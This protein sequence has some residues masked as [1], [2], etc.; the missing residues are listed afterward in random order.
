MKLRVL[1]LGKRD[2]ESTLNI[3]LDL[4][5]KRQRGLIEDTLVLVEHPPVITM[6]LSAKDSNILM[7]EKFLMEQGIDVHR[8]ARGGDVTYHGDGQIVGYPI[9]NLKESKL[10]IRN[11]V[12]GMEK[13]FI[14]ILID[15]F[16]INAAKDP[17]HTGVWVG[18]DKIVAIG[19]AVKHGVTMHGFAFNVNT[20]LQHFD[21]I[22]PCGLNDRGVTSIEKIKG[23]KQDFENINELVL[24]YFYKQFGFD[25]IE[26]IQ[27]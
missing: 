14:D 3:Q 2:Y 13:L 16:E 19:L 15:E 27:L 21:Y 9:F 25:E 5:D 10:G 6:G 26:M 1:K 8:I 22:V 18:N 4:L 23:E 17:G 11:F 12:E 24:K 20:N 7:S